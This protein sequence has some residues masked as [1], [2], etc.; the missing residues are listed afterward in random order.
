MQI[1]KAVAIL[2]LLVGSAY[3]QLMGY[4]CTTTP[5]SGSCATSDGPAFFVE[6]EVEIFGSCYNASYFPYAGHRAWS[7]NCP[8]QANARAYGDRDPSHIGMVTAEAGLTVLAHIWGYSA[9]D[10][11]GFRFGTPPYSQDGCGHE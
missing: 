9:E 4:L 7:A 10:C 6:A 8:D 2:L 11:E 5:Y 3:S 1:T